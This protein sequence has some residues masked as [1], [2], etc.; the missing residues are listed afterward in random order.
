M[1]KII[2]TLEEVSA[3]RNRA[4]GRRYL[5][6][7]QRVAER[8]SYLTGVETYFDANLPHALRL[9]SITEKEI[10]AL[11]VIGLMSNA[12]VPETTIYRRAL[13][14][15]KWYGRRLAILAEEERLCSHS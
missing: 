12:H 9:Q 2:L 10:E 7:R 11:M 14:K 5:A 6:M 13:Q 15:G 3:L 8:F 4:T 1:T